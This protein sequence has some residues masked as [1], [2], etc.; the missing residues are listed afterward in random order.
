ME[1]LRRGLKDVDDERFWRLYERWKSETLIPPERLYAS[2]QALSTVIRNGDAGAVVECGVFRGGSFCF[3]MDLAQELGDR[4][5]RFWA[6]DTFD[7]FPSEVAEVTWKGE[8][9]SRESWHTDNF[10]GI[11]EENLKRVDYPLEFVTIVQGSVIETLPR[12]APNEIAF[13]HLDTDYY[14]ATRVE[15]DLL[16]DRVSR[17]GAIEVDDYNAFEGSRRAVDEFL[18]GCDRRPL[19]LRSDR[20]GRMLIKV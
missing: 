2:Y 12:N 7:G 19:M 6:Y 13:L 20:F 11:F 9:F 17:G 8:S 15:L 10:R 1:D 3:L 5:R 4:S 14:E 18:E 16:Y